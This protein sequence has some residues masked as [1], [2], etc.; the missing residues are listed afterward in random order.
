LLIWWLLEV[1]KVVNFRTRGINRG[2][3]KLA[4]TLILIIIKK[5][6]IILL[7]TYEIIFRGFMLILFI[8]IFFPYC[9]GKYLFNGASW[10]INHRYNIIIKIIKKTKSQLLSNSMM[11]TLA[12]KYGAATP[13][14]KERIR[15]FQYKVS[16]L[17]T[18][19]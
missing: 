12:C 15:D 6:I 19:N 11:A 10:T 3:R 17:E 16:F 5:T 2:I 14:K 1:Y 7:W 13:R 4:R 9:C 18:L 8:Y